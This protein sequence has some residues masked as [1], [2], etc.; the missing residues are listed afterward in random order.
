MR[1]LGLVKHPEGGYYREVYRSKNFLEE[2]SL[3]AGF[4]GRRSMSTGIYFL[5]KGGQFSAF[6]RIRSDEVWH[7]YAG[8]PLRLYRINPAGK[9]STVYLGADPRKRCVFQAAVRAGDWFAAEVSVKAGFSLVGCTT[10]PGFDFRDFELA[11]KEDL[12][13][14]YPRWKA[15]IQRLTR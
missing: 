15:L 1:R 5:L 14:R 6:H 9:L 7:F 10:A 2:K 11:K 8:S 3:P 12:S 13:A 4:A